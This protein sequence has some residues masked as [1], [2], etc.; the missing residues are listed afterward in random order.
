VIVNLGD[1]TLVDADVIRFL[2]CSEQAGIMLVRCPPYVR[3]WI[4]RE[5][6][7]GQT[8]SMAPNSRH[9]KAKES[10]TCSEQE[11]WSAIRYLDPDRDLIDRKS[12]VLALKRHQ[13]RHLDL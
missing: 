3:E 1:V 9:Y 13:M 2:G 6:A 12:V 8:L 5:C 7:E 10:Q 4:R 11:I